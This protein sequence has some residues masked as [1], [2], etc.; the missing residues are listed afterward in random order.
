MLGLEVGFAGLRLLTSLASENSS[1]FCIDVF[2]HN[3]LRGIGK[4]TILLQLSPWSWTCAV[5]RR[6]IRVSIFREASSSF[7][8]LLSF[9]F[10]Q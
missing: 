8:S 2:A 10:S 6:V 5:A 1:F 7:S 4:R 3:F 9:E